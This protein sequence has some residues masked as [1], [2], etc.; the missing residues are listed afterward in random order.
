MIGTTNRRA[1]ARRKANTVV[2]LDQAYA[3]QLYHREL[4]LINRAWAER[5]R[6]EAVEQVLSLPDPCTHLDRQP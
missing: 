5:E 3:E 4:R 1:L 6:R 2:Q